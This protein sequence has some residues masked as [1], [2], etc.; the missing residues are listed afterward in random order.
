MKEL[1]LHWIKLKRVR[2]NGA[3]KRTDLMGII[4]KCTYKILNFT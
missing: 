2:I 4:K 1:E 3:G